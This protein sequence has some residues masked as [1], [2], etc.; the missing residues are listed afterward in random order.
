MECRRAVAN[1]PS[2]PRGR[3]GERSD[4]DLAATYPCH[5]PRARRDGPL[6][7]TLPA[8]VHLPSPSRL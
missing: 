1:S 4:I 3:E 7:K 6:D 5:V 2:P 8:I